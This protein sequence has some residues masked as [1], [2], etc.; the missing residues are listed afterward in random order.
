M[1]RRR[2]RDVVGLVVGASVLVI[3]GSLA[4]RGVSEAEADAFR[5][6][7]GLPDGSYGAVWVPMQYGTFGTVPA[8]SALAVLAR[9]P[10]LALA[11]GAAGTSAWVLAKAIKPVV[12]RARPKGLLA[13]VRLR[14]EEEG[15]LGFPSG[16]AAVS[17][18]MTIVLLPRVPPGYRP[19][20]VVL[21]VFVPF[22]RWYVGRI[23]RLT[24]SGAPRWERRSARQSTWRWACRLRRWCRAYASWRSASS[25]EACT[26][27]RCAIER[28]GSIATSMT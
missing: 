4:R 3:S 11:L 2:A 25:T 22:A 21:S 28:S 17:A 14:G 16:H 19:L 8:L 18:A 5:S 26:C 9:R 10:R 1:N 20:A 27:A 23:F 13:D 7:N 6:V 24:R 12:G 15:D